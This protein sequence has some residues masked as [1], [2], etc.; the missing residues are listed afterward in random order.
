MSVWWRPVVGKGEGPWALATSFWKIDM[1]ANMLGHFCAEKI[2][3][4]L[5]KTH[6]LTDGQTFVSKC[7][8]NENFLKRIIMIHFFSSFRHRPRERSKSRFNS[9]TSK[10]SLRLLKRQRRQLKRR[11][12][13]RR[14]FRRFW[15]NKFCC[16]MTKQ[17]L[18]LRLC[19]RRPIRGVFW[20]R[21]VPTEKVCRQVGRLKHRLLLLKLDTQPCS[22]LVVKVAS[23]EACQ[24]M[25][26]VP[27]PIQ[28]GTPP[29][30][31]WHPPPPTGHPTP[32]MW[33]AS[34]AARKGR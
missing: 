9:S 34:F 29:P 17:F 3:Y 26:T 24:G 13:K 30:L 16:W 12:A 2:F 25:F 7:G 11:L 18:N 22:H 23:N 1:S 20:L 15:K 14:R 28:H 27:H 10:T 33:H 4:L 31:I 8:E 5:N 6:R 21:W 19:D 32:S